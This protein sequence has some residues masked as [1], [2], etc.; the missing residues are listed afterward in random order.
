MRKQSNWVDILEM[1][2]FG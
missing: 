2:L 1:V